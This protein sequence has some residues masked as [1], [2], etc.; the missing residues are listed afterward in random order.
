MRRKG[1]KGPVA[2]YKAYKKTHNTTLTS[3]EFTAVLECFNTKVLNLL[4]SGVEVKMPF[5]TG[6]MYVVKK[7]VNYDHL[8]LDYGHWRKTGEKLFHTNRHSDGFVAH[9]H[10]RKTGAVFINKTLYEL[11][12]CRNACRRLAAVMKTNG[13]HKSFQQWVPPTS[14][15]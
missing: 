12:F 4:L 6:S 8:S 15:K 1:E 10:W 7:K 14:Y 13:G 2:M 9:F 11:T 5:T 3:R